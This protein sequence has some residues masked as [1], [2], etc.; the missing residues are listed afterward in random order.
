VPSTP[1]KLGFH[2]RR[3]CGYYTISNGICVAGT[4]SRQN[5]RCQNLDIIIDCT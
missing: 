5:E 1:I 3:E 4:R 2:M